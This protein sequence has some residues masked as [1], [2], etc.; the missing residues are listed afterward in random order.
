M[1][2]T[3]F[4]FRQVLII[5]LLFQAINLQAIDV[6]NNIDKDF[7]VF[8]LRDIEA[9]LD[10]K[11]IIKEKFIPLTSL[12]NN[13]FDNGVY[14]LKIVPKTSL[15]FNHIFEIPFIHT[16]N[17]ELYSNG[18]K[19]S[20]RSNT[21]YILF[22]LIRKYEGN[23]LY[24][25]VNCKKEALIPITIQHQTTYQQSFNYFSS[26][27]YYIVLLCVLILHLVCFYEFGKRTYLNYGFMLITFGS[28]LAYRDGIFRLFLDPLV[29]EHIEL[30]FNLATG[31]AFALFTYDFLEHKRYIPKYKWWSITLLIIPTLSYIT[32]LLKPSYLG[33]VIT[34]DL[35]ILSLGT[36]CFT[37][38]FVYKYTFFAKAFAW[39]YFP[40]LLLTIVYYNWFFFGI[41]IGRVDIT[42]YRIGGIFEMAVFSYVIIYR[43]R[44]QLEENNLLKVELDN[45]DKVLDVFTT[46][47]RNENSKL[48]NTKNQLNENFNHS[49]NQNTQT[50]SPAENGEAMKIIKS[51]LLASSLKTEKE[52]KAF[53]ELFEQVHIGFFDRLNQQWPT[54][55]PSEIK[56]IALSRLKLQNREATFMLH[57]SADAL[58]QVKSRLGKKI[59]LNK[60]ITLIE[61]VAGI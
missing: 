23:T 22:D 24:A 12:I 10:A 27:S 19:I 15:E 53:V 8:W 57:V 26:S 20:P 28:S 2:N 46:D 48:S 3:L 31:Y 59:G 7:N 39:A 34:D 25:R 40:M 60:D 21:R 56:L 35:I 41:D 42:L 5:F 61:F 50:S 30:F 44:K 37:S 16:T 43:A 58:R 51:Q 33:H 49:L 4:M 47:L 32:Y 45:R 6:K 55:T 14:W 1:K 17:V 52:W 38:L 13:G 29:H 36:T 9:Q 18:V 54:L 11:T